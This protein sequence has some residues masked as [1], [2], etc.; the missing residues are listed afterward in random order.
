MQNAKQV[1]SLFKFIRSS[2]KKHAQE[3]FDV[4]RNTL[5]DM[6]K[7]HPSAYEEF[8]MVY[9]FGD[10]EEFDESRNDYY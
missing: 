5:S 10:P 4:A 8:A 1:V 9:L 6:V 7:G 3:L 2:Q